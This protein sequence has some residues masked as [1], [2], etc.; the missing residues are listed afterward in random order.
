MKQLNQLLPFVQD[1]N[2]RKILQEIISEL[3][4]IN[5]IPAVSTTTDI[6]K[7]RDA[8]NKIIGKV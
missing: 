4:R 6:S 1:Q 7:V 8:V 3:D 5:S 2:V